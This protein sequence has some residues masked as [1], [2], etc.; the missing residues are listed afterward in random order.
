M[1][2]NG[3]V[4]RSVGTLEYY[5]VVLDIVTLPCLHSRRQRHGVQ[6]GSNMM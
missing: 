5:V 4:L 1:L 6:S 2:D 3:T